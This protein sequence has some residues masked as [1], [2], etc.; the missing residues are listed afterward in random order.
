VQWLP[1]RATFEF[2]AN[3]RNFRQRRADQNV[4]CNCLGALSAYAIHFKIQICQLADLALA[5][6]LA[7]CNSTVITEFIVAEPAQEQKS[8]SGGYMV[9]EFLANLRDFRQ[10]RINAQ[11]VG[12]RNDALSSVCASAIFVHAAQFVS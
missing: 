12:N 4:S 11:G 8:V 5:Q 2:W 7:Q 1:N 9:G 10:R 6:R 3:L